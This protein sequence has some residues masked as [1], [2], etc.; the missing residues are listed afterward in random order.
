MNPFVDDKHS[1]LNSS[2]LESLPKQGLLSKV[3]L[4]TAAGKTTAAGAT[5]ADYKSTLKESSTMGQ[6]SI[7]HAQRTR[8]DFM[9]GK[10]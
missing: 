9:F 7:I 1:G 6:G 10:E 8:E 2:K 4:D 5:T 3:G